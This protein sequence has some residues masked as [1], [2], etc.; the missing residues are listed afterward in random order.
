MPPQTSTPLRCL[1]ATVLT[2][3]LS[4]FSPVCSL[5][6][7]TGWERFRGPNGHGYV[8]D[9]RI[10][11][12]WTPADYRWQAELPGGGVGSAVVK[13]G[14]VFLITAEPQKNRRLVL[15][16]E[17]RSGRILWEAEYPLTPHRLHSRNTFASTTPAVDESHVYVAWA[18]PQRVV[19]AA[20]THEGREVWSVD[21]GPWQSQHGF[22]TS[23]V[24]LDGRL[25]I[26]NSQQAEQLESDEKAGT[27]QM[28][29]LDPQ[30]GEL[31]WKTQLSTTYACY[32]VPALFV[33]PEGE[34][35][36]V[37][38]NQG[39]GLLGL[40]LETGE[41]RWNR[42]VFTMRCVS[43]PVVAGDLVLASAGSGGGGN[44]LVAIRPGK[45]E[46]DGAAQSEG[47]GEAEEAYRMT[48]A[49]PYV[50]TP[51]LVGD[52]L[53]LVDDRGIA[54]CLEASTGKSLW[55]KRIGGTY[56]A[57]PIVLGDKVLLISLEGEAT[58]LRAS[59]T[60][61]QLGQFD[62]GG[63]VQ[64]TPAWAEGCLLLRIGNRLCCLSGPA[65]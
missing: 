49:A 57:S 58:V 4:A 11:D 60:F 2:A 17:L 18:D 52:R 47:A 20:L 28:V 65:A 26:L 40:D 42:D 13:N 30:T 29:A 37:A 3:T 31:L 48:R 45:S 50:P 8:A 27:S 12:S 38:A 63:P 9:A 54:S 64:A 61:E 19:V 34:R 7:D 35:Q 56:S 10:P 44:H 36:V 16:I 21:L 5:A 15:G 59:D 25:I 22:G 62:L 41:L 1:V 46:V 43:S 33:S 32:G 23:P 39:D 24:L 14:K 55:S 6:A 53:F 51:A